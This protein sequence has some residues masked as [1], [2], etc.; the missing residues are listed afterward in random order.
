MAAKAFF[1]AQFG[2]IF[3]ISHFTFFSPI[4]LNLFAL[5]SYTCRFSRKCRVDK[6]R[7][8]SCRFCRFQKCLAAGMRAEAIQNQRNHLLLIR[9]F[10]G[11]TRFKAIELAQ[12]VV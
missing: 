4:K 8:N 9:F 7:R 1:V 5:C 3:G 2:K 12:L 6:S 11:N 10:A